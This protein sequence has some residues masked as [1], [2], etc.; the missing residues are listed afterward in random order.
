MAFA[1]RLVEEQIKQ[2]CNISN[3]QNKLKQFNKK[4]CD[5]LV[6]E[7]NNQYGCKPLK[8]KKYFKKN[9]KKKKYKKYW[10]KK[11]KPFKPGTYFKKKSTKRQIKILSER[12]EEMQM[13]DLQ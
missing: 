4:C 1:Q 2:Y 8:T 7:S 12:K 10:K 5:S 13:L 6:Y 3:I 9:Y 11:K